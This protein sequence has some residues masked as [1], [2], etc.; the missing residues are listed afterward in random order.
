MAKKIAVYNRKGGVGKTTSLLNL[1]AELALL[2]NRVLLIDGDSQMNLTQYFFMDIADK[3]DTDEVNE[4]EYVL[5]QGRTIPGVDNLYTVLEN[6][7]PIFDAIRT[8]ERSSK[9]KIKNRFKT[10]TC[11][12]DILLGSRNM[13]YYAPEDMNEMKELVKQ[14]DKEYDYILIDFPPQNSDITMMYLVACDYLIAPLHLGA[15]SS[16]FAYNDIIDCCEEAKNE[17]N[18]DKL[19]RLGAYYMQTQLYKTSQQEKYME[20]MSEEVRKA[21][22]FFKT[23]IKCDYATSRLAEEYKEPLCICAGRSEIAKNY[24]DLA[25]EILK[26]IEEVENNE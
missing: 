20:S 1:G 23:T 15:D 25:K 24:K 6:K 4:N 22:R 7:L 14:A 26:R 18:N 2:K 5:S 9:R 12:F 8:V 16:L 17:Y 13:D 19:V 21:M 10:V 3:D 11:K